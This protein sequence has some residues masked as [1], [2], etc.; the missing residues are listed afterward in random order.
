MEPRLVFSPDK[1][2]PEEGGLFFELI[3]ETIEQSPKSYFSYRLLDFQ[4]KCS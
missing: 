4:L 2:I 1:K 3:Q